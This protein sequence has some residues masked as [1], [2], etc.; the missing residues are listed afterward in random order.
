VTPVKIFSIGDV[1]SIVASIP[2][3]IAGYVWTAITT[4]GLW[5]SLAIILGLIGWV[6]FEVATRNG[7]AHYNSDNGFSPLFNIF[8]GSSLNF[9]IQ[10]GMGLGLAKIFGDTIY[11]V[12]WPYILHFAVF[13]I[14]G[15][16]LRFTGF[17]V[18]LRILGERPRK[19]GRR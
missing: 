8:V 17:W 9:A 4:L 3:T 15:L 19:R 11:C 7:N 2:H 10:E 14:T 18:Y 6:V 1:C 13:V 16:F 5:W 12:E